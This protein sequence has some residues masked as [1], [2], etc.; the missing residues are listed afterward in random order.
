MTFQ[1]TEA[2]TCRTLV[3]PALQLAG[4]ERSPRWVAKQQGERADFIAYFTRDLP[5]T[6]SAKHPGHH[7]PGNKISESILSSFCHE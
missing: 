2:D 4:W 1:V 5:Q 6:S 3:T 7:P